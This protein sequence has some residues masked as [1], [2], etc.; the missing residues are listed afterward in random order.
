M[1]IDGSGGFA[2]IIEPTTLQ[3]ASVFEPLDFGFA[4]AAMVSAVSPDCEISRVIVS[5]HDGIAGIATRSHNRLRLGLAPS[6]SIM[7]LPAKPA[8]QTG[9][10][11]GDIELLHRL[12]SSAV[13]CISSRKT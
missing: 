1:G 10:A 4:L 5:G 9:A 12:N 3:M 8:C 11:G 7:N 2:V 6:V 13:T